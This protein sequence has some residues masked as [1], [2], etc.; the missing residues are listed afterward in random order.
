LIFC[1]GLQVSGRS[2]AM[3]VVPSPSG[4]RHAGQFAAPTRETAAH[5]TIKVKLHHFVKLQSF[6]F[7]L[8]RI[9]FIVLRSRM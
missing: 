6:D 2:L 5:A 4:P 8:A 9:A 7:G 1:A 3:V